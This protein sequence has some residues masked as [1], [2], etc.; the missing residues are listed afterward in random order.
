MQPMLASAAT[1]LPHGAGWTYEFKWDG[2][3]ALCDTTPTRVRLFSRRGNEITTAYPE[4]AALAGAGA[5]LDGEIVAF[6]D[7]RPSFQALQERMHVRKATDARRLAEKTPVTFMAFDLLVEDGID[8]TGL[9]L[10]ERRARLEVY[11]ADHAITVSPS[12]DDAAATEQVARASGLEGVMAKRLTSRYRPGLRT[13]DWVKLRF[14]NSGD[15]AV[16]GW[17]ESREHPGALSSLVLATMTPDGPMFAGKVGSGLTGRTAATLQR[18]LADRSTCPLPELPP[19]S[20]GG[21][22]VHWV[23]PAVVVEVKYTLVTTDGRLR[24]P[25]FLRVRSDK[26][27]EEAT[28]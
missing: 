28:G 7:G 25:V 17:E 21:R 20:P 2:V 26:D 27:I 6:V 24:Q 10:R 22:V 3:R 8:L 15:F 18:Q 19:T 12:F 23:D 16:V 1:N 11:A 14:L 5:T 9:P 13:T 4:L